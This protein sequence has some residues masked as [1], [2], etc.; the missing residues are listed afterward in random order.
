MTIPLFSKTG[1]EKKNPSKFFVNVCGFYQ[2]CFIYLLIYLFILP[3]CSKIFLL[4]KGPPLPVLLKRTFIPD[5]QLLIELYHG[6]TFVMC[7]QKE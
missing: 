1:F 7:Y 2:Q 5:F 4:R 3:R 6:A